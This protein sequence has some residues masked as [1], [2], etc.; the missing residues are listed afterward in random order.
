ML[1]LITKSK[2]RQKIILFFIYNPQRRYYINETARLA[3]TSSGTAKRELER[4]KK[5]GILTKERENK[6][7]YFKLNV[8]N[9]IL[10]DIKNIVDKTIGLEHILKKELARVKNIDFVFIF[11]SYAKNDFKPDSDIDLYIIGEIK[12]GELY[13]KLRKAEERTNKM[14]NY[15]LSTKEEFKKN[16]KKSFF[17]KEILNKHIL[18]IGAENEFKKFIK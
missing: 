6:L 17:H 18:I 14:I 1:D 7:V 13:K 16:L 5:A 4:L 11:G 3:K 15:H 10:P 12:E 2:I 9:P 8:A